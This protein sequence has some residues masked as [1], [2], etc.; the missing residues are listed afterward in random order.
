MEN[1]VK[2]AALFTKKVTAKGKTYYLDV[3]LAKNGNKYLT[4]TES[5]AQPDGS[6]NRRWVMVF[7]DGIEE[8]SKAIQEAATFMQHKS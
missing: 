6:S 1:S 8:F 7:E 4:V 5:G 3:R 2:T